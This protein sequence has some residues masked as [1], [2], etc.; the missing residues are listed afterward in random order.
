MS[1]TASRA[2]QPMTRK[3]R[4][5]EDW[6]R[7]LRD[8]ICSV[9]EQIEDFGDMADGPAGRFASKLWKRDGGGGG[10]VSLMHGRI[11]E[12]VGVNI[13]DRIRRFL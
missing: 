7:N 8:E 12:K 6:F 13:S 2:E 3:K 5:A 9:F 1:L 4:E 11:F 10:E